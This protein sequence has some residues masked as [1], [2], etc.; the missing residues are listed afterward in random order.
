MLRN[1]VR[2]SVVDTGMISPCFCACANNIHA[3][4]SRL[5]RGVSGAAV[6]WRLSAIVHAVV[7]DYAGDAQPVIRENRR[8]ALALGL[9]VL[10]HIAPCRDSLLIA[11]DR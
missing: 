10:R 1:V 7:A 9:A 11:E 8:A 4:C 5:V 6:L 3:P 2:L